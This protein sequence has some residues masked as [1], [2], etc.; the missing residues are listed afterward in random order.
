METEFGAANSSD[1]HGFV[2]DLM[3]YLAHNE[4]YIGWTAWAA[5]PVWRPN[6]QAVG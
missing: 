4:E 1:C 6:S 5:G 3:E 2:T